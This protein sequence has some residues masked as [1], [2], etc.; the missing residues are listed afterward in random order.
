MNRDSV[1]NFLSS[2]VVVIVGLAIGFVIL[3]FSNASQ[4]IP[5]FGTL[6][7]QGVSS[8]RDIG[9]VL[10]RATPII[11]TGLSVAF[12]FKTGLFN[13][14]ATGQF[15]FGAFVAILISLRT[16]TMPADAFQHVPNLIYIGRCA[17]DGT[18]EI[19]LPPAAR[20]VSSVLAAT[21]AGALWGSIPGLLKAFFNV[22]EVITCIMTNY[23]AMYLVSHL[24]DWASI[25][26][27]GLG[28]TMR[29]PVDSTL[30][31][32]GMENIFVEYIGATNFPWTSDINIGILLAVLFAI[33]VYIILEKT[34]FG[35]ELKA[36]GFNRDAA[37]YAGINE[38]RN[39]ILS[40]V[41]CG[42]LS[43]FAGALNFL[44]D[45]GLPLSAMNVLSQE[46]F[47]GIS[48]AFLG[49]N[50][51]I[52]IIFSGVL[53]SY[54]FH[55]GGMM[56]EFGFSAHLV[57]IV[58]GVIIYFCAFVMLVKSFLEKFAM[59]IIS[60]LKRIIR[61]LGRKKQGEESD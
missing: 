57:E 47:T 38:K 37:K 42:A 56:Q 15:M 8:M 3:L 44:N 25:L 50:H 31:T 35:Y 39:I 7:A 29:L 46:G 19:F 6:L 52:G 2:I 28:G 18:L 59:S 1:Y 60:F 11:L 4:A 13:I 45:T 10:F 24:I 26:D 23:I 48:V 20:V 34:S 36:C 53:V 40:L 61:K 33:L 55:G 14:G 54:I 32:L 49:L 9:D 16:A 30:P 58:I 41:I 12:A 5:A 22:H 21:L 51:P 17:T 43:G 27:Q